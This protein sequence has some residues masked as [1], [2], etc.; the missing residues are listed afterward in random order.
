[1]DSNSKQYNALACDLIG[2][3]NEYFLVSLFVSQD[4]MFEGATAFNQNIGDWDVS[5][6]TDFVSTEH[7]FGFQFKTIHK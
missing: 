1:M 4:F 7:S 3:S 6:G 5:S 2:S